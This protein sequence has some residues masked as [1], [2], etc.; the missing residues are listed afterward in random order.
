MSQTISLHS[1]AQLFSLGRPPGSR[2]GAPL[3]LTSG[4]AWYRTGIVNVAFIG[5]PDAGDRGWVLVDTGIPGFADAIAHAAE[6]RFG[7]GARPA[8]I[9]L[10][11]G[12]FDHV[13]SAKALAE[14]WDV[15]IYV[16]RLELPY[17][18]GGGPYPPPD[19]TVGGGALA[20]MAMFYPRGPVDLGS[21]VMVL[22]DDGSVPF[23][24]E[25]TWIN[26]AGHSPGHVSFFRKRDRALIA[27]DAFVT[28]KQEAV[29]AV[30]TQRVELR[31]PPMHFTPDW[32]RARDSVR[33]LADREPETAITGHGQPMTGDTLR[34]ALHELADS[35]D[36][37]A[38]PD[39]GRY[40]ERPAITDARGVVALPPAV[41]DP[42]PYA[43]AAAVGVFAGIWM[44]RRSPGELARRSRHAV[45]G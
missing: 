1:A 34:E 43:L 13:G 14:R 17:V 30:W 29:A 19:G 35:F 5:E 11:H 45:R 7:D 24:P 6:L 9:L 25:W 16:H 10:T 27:G 42:L 4:L 3:P 32:D 44:L 26:T 41:F 22:P 28:T 38:R 40:R 23:A 31:G 2:D 18:T 20:R 8:A 15:P 39:H 36:T 37:L 33:R 21:R 12:H